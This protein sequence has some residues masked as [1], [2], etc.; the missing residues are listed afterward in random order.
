MYRKNQKDHIYIY[1]EIHIMYI[2]TY[3]NIQLMWI[4]IFFTSKVR[5]PED[6]YVRHAFLFSFQGWAPHG[7]NHPMAPDLSVD[8]WM[9]FFGVRDKSNLFPGQTH[10]IQA[11]LVGPLT[12]IGKSKSLTGGRCHCTVHPDLG[13]WS[14]L[15]SGTWTFSLENPIEML[16]VL[17]LWNQICR[18]WFPST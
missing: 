18:F 12:L 9:F 15:I 6:G 3:I 16:E 10:E 11:F 8:M 5:G 17:H 4:E 2:H 7:M 1:I 14:D 13:G